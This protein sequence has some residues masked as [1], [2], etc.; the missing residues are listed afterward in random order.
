[1]VLFT[2]LS[3]PVLELLNLLKSFK[4]NTY[5]SKFGKVHHYSSL[6]RTCFNALA[7]TADYKV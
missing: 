2:L 1:M 3:T 4:I 6:F 7:F 5:C